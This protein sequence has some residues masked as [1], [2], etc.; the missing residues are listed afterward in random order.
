MNSKDNLGEL[1]Y[2]YSHI[3]FVSIFLPQLEV[4]LNSPESNFLTKS[5]RFSGFIPVIL[6]GSSTPLEKNLKVGTL[7]TPLL[8][9]VST[10]TLP[11]LIFGY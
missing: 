11:N 2:T 6:W 7:D 1:F 4:A 9:M 8:G 5:L 3:F 10:F